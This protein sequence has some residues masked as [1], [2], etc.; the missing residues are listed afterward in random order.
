[1]VFQ[2][3]EDVGSYLNFRVGFCSAW[4]TQKWENY[5]RLDVVS[6]QPFSL[7][8]CLG[9]RNGT[10]S[11]LSIVLEI[12]N[13]PISV[14]QWIDTFTFSHEWCVG[15]GKYTNGQETVLVIISHNRIRFRVSGFS[16]LGLAVLLCMTSEFLYIAQ[17]RSVIVICCTCHSIDSL[18]SLLNVTSGKVEMKDRIGHPSS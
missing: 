4:W 12:F 7:S 9:R 17:P 18:P 11:K 16:F 1:M 5:M 3:A 10:K 8:C 2:I 13:L 15:H 14:R 6:E